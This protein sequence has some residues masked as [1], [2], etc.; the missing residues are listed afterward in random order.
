MQNSLAR[1]RY[2]YDDAAN[3]V[4]V[5]PAN[6]RTHVVKPYHRRLGQPPEKSLLYIVAARDVEPRRLRT[7]FKCAR[8]QAGTSGRAN[9][10]LQLALAKTVDQMNDKSTS[11]GCGS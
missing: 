3:D 1:Y 8:T 10:V 11:S 4:K 6:L 9:E 5:E 7:R 2:S